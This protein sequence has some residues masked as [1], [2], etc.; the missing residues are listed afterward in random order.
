MPLF[1]AEDEESVKKRFSYDGI[2]NGIRTR[3]TRMRTWCPGPL[4]DR[5]MLPVPKNSLI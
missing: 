3:V 4:D 5:D 1:H 2:P